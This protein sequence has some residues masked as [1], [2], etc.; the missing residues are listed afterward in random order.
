[1]NTFFSFN[2]HKNLEMFDE[3][4]KNCKVP[5]K[6]LK[7]LKV[8]KISE[9]SATFLQHFSDYLEKAVKKEEKFDENEKG[10]VI[11]SNF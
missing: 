11:S 7:P 5:E 4:A 6:L 2:I 1:M 8:H 10:K 9:K 3:M